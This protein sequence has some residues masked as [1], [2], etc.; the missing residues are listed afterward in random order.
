MRIRGFNP[1][2]RA[3]TETKWYFSKFFINLFTV[4]LNLI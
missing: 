1:K 2:E 3:F 4:Q